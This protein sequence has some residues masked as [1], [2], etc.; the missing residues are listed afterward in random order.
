[1]KNHTNNQ[2]YFKIIFFATSI[3]VFILAIVS[4]DH[5]NIDS[6][7]ADKLKHIF[8]FVTLSLLLNR[9]S[10]NIE[11]RLRNMGALLLFG[12]FIEFVQYFLP[13]RDASIEDVVA[14]FIGILLFQLVYSFLKFMQELLQ[15]R[16][17]NNKRL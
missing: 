17:L 15:K 4:N 13:N 12:L 14:D 8:A 6:H 10:S 9:S 3:I 7:Y 1:M 2:S 5:I 16:E 11:K